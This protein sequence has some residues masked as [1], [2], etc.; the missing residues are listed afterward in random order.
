[1]TT[2]GSPQ[3]KFIGCICSP[4][5][6]NGG[7]G[8]SLNLAMPAFLVEQNCMVH[9]ATAWNAVAPRTY[10]KG[11]IPGVSTTIYVFD[12]ISPSATIGAKSVMLEEE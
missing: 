3:A 11:F 5:Y 4:I 2:P 8:C 7:T 12:E 9:G 10:N 6:N 1:M